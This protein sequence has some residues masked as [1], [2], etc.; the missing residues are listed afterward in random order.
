MQRMYYSTVIF[1]KDSTKQCSIQFCKNLGIEMSFEISGCVDDVMQYNNYSISIFAIYRSPNYNNYKLFFQQL[2]LS[3]KKII[4]KTQY[5]VICGD[6]NINV[7]EQNSITN[8]LK[9]FLNSFGVKRLVNTPTRI[10]GNSSMSIDN[11]I[12]N[13]PDD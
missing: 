13:L 12:T 2:Q 8:K 3:L 1:T 5:F 7:L 10:T 11:I 6:M 9:Y 4:S